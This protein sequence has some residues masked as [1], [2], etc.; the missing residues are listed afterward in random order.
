VCLL[1]VG[2]YGCAAHSDVWESASRDPADS[3]YNLL[4]RGFFSG[5]LNLRKDVPT[6]FAELTDPY[7]PAANANFRLGSDRLHDMSYYKGQLYLYFGITPALILL[8]P[9]AKVTRHF[10]SSGQASA[11]FCIV[12]FLAGAGVLRALWRRYF[13]DTRVWVVAAGTLAFG[14][15]TGVPIMLPRSGVYEVAVSCG[16]M[17]AMLSLA[18]I[19]PAVHAT[20]ERRRCWCLAAASMAYGLAV[21]ARPSLLFGAVILLVPVFRPRPDRRLVWALLAAVLP[22]FYL[23]LGMLVYNR[24]RF[25][26]PFEFG[27]RYQLAAVTIRHYF[28]W[29]Y[30][31]FNFW[32]Y[33]LEPVRW[34][35]HYPFVTGFTEPV[36]PAGRAVEDAFGTLTNTPIVWLALALPLAWRSRPPEAR[37]TLRAFFTAAVVFFGVHALTLL[38]FVFAC[39]RYQVEFLPALMLLAVVGIL[40]LDRVLAN[41]LAWR[42]AARCGWGLLLGF[43]VAFNIL[44]CAIRCAEADNNLGLALEEHGQVEE[45]V[46]AYHRAVLLNPLYAEA[47]SNLGTAL[48][49]LGEPQAGLKQFEKAVQLQPGWA[50]THYNLGVALERVNGRTQEAIEQYQEALRI[51]PNHGEAHFHLANSLARAARFE[52]AVSQYREALR[53]KPDDAEACLNLG[54]ALARLG[55]SDAAIQEYQEAL[56]YQPD[57]A[58]VHNSWANTLMREGKPAEAIEHYQQAL[59]TFPGSVEIHYNLAIAL[60]RAGRVPEAIEQFQ[61]ALKLQ[62]DLTAAKNALTRLRA[63]P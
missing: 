22:I 49:G 27:V 15:G 23:G 42:R 11:V 44:G 63:S 20:T 59:Q 14:L 12:G 37:S 33:F 48:I 17:L 45:A 32:Y 31:G 36:L 40:G 2:V 58:V 1:V 16:Y 21:G 51:D 41:R 57:Y 26:N 50:S 55:R 39:I 25:D 5:Q 7:N 30:L 19:W 4:V 9:Y 18:A 6:G 56:C 29:R 60:E 35:G 10:L 43:S 46:N 52:D 53:L 62:P 38:L 47:H 13:S 8:W 54:V 24:L 61:L 3:Y 28:S 34:M